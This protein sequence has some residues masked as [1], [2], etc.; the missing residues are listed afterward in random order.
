MEF[1]LDT[2]T[3]IWGIGK[4][5]A[6]SN[7]V[8]ELFDDDKN[9]FFVSAVSLWEIAIKHH[10]GKLQLKNFLITEIPDYCERLGFELIALEPKIALQS[11]QLPKRDNCD[12][13]DRMLIFQAIARNWTFVSK[14]RSIKQYAND[15]LKYV[16]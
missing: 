5:T 16:W 1:L 7:K 15:G 11:A 10:S 14:D 6:L 8:R 3:L 4:S 9:K 12:P 13:F 2:H